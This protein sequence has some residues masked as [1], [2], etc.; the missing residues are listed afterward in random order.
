M[1][2]LVNALMAQ[3][4]ERG[5]AIAEARVGMARIRNHLAF[6]D[7]DLAIDEFE[8]EFGLSPEVFEEVF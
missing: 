6:G 5:D 7:R 3:G 4:M 2:T 1:G 8:E